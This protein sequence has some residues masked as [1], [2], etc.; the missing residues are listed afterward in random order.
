MAIIQ[1]LFALVSRSLGRIASSIFGWAVV[2]LFGQTNGSEKTALSVLVGAAA[3]WP[4]LLLGVAAPKVATFILGF[5]Q[6]PEW[7]PSWTVR[8][9]W[10]FLAVAVPLGVG[11]TMAKRQPQARRGDHE[12]GTVAPRESALKRLLRGFPITVG[13]AAAFMV[14]FVTVPALR[15]MSMLRRRIDVQVPLVT[16]AADYEVIASRVARTLNLH[17]FA[18]REAQ[19]GWW[20]TLPPR[21][22]LTLGGAAFRA[23]IP[24]R[25]AYFSGPELDVAL[26]PNALLLRGGHQD[27]AWAQG[28]VVE[29]L[30]DAPAFQTFDPGAHDIERQIRR[31]WSVYRE[32]PA[33]HA[34]SAALLER[35]TEIS[36]DIRRLPVAYDE[37]QVVYRQAVQLGRALRGES[38]L[39]QSASST[40]DTEEAT[41]EKPMSIGRNEEGA[42][43]LSNRALVG[44]IADRATLLAKKDFE[45]AKA[46]IRADLKSELAMAK[47]LGAAAVAALM[48]LQLMLVAVVLALGSVMPGWLAAVILGGA[49]LAFSGIMA[50]V[51]WRKHVANPLPLTRQTLKQQMQWLKERVA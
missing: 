48:G 31:V 11:V 21:I 41:E 45:L 2:A 6:V 10:I 40:N 35:L 30:T 24:Q 23:Y 36:R 9:A 14:V 27:A 50:Y 17:G 34:N 29:A 8:V 16:A 42:R 3:A 43:H 39:L 32:H 38:Q 5:I 12:A 7:I 37:W 51:G 49:M 26:Y 46:E 22:L 28:V 19:P 44:E 18:V 1:S 13:I 20:M 15:V 47:A 33:A 4:V 25:L